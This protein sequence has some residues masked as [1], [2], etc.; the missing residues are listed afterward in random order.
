VRREREE[1]VWVLGFGVER[2]VGDVVV[3]V[4]VGFMGWVGEVAVE[5]GGDEEDL[6]FWR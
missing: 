1:G 2:G 3:V 4:D 5:K 6:D